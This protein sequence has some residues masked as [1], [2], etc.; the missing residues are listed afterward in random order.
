MALPT[1]DK[2]IIKNLYCSD[3]VQCAIPSV[4]QHVSFNGRSA[5]FVDKQTRTAYCVTYDSVS[6]KLKVEENAT[7]VRA[8][9][10]SLSENILSLAGWKDA[11]ARKRR[12]RSVL[13]RRSANRGDWRG[14]AESA[15][16]QEL[17]VRGR[18]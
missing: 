8:S 12:E 14:G 13:W 6:G 5:V 15:D 9:L 18:E 4:A 2:I 16:R 3:A 17:H 10:S 11:A 7:K 1:L